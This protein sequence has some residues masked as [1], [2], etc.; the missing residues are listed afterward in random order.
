MCALI[1]KILFFN[2]YI[3]FLSILISQF[4]ILSPAYSQ[5][6]INIT[7]A[8]VIS[9]KIFEFDIF[10]KSTGND[11]ILSS[12]QCALSCDNVFIN[13]GHLSFSYISSSSDLNNYPNYSIG[14]Q[15]ESGIQKLCFASTVGYDTIRN[16]YKKIGKFRVVNSNQFIY[17]KLSIN[18]IFDQNIRTLITD[19]NFVDITH[20]DN[21]VNLQDKISILNIPFFTFNEDDSL[22]INLK[23][24]NTY[25]QNNSNNLLNYTF[26]SG[27][28]VNA[29]LS[30]STIKLTAASNWNGTDSITLK[31][32]NGISEAVK[33]IIVKVLPVNDPPVI[34]KAGNQ[35]TTVNVPKNMTIQFTD[36]DI[37]DTHT[38]SII[39]DN[40]N[41]TVANLSGNISGST[42]NLIPKT[43]WSGT[44]NIK[45]TV[46]DNGI[47]NL[48]GSDTYCLTIT[49]TNTTLT[50]SRIPDIYLYEDQSTTFNKSFFY[51]Y[52]I[53][54]EKPDSLL[55]F[56]FDSGQNVRARWKNSTLTLTPNPNWNGSDSIKITVS[57]GTYEVTKGIKVIVD[58][59]ND[60]PVLTRVG[61]QK[62]LK[63]QSKKMIVTYSDPDS[64]ETHTISIVSDNP[65]VNIEDLNG[66]TSGSIY[67]L[68]P[69]KDWY[70]TANITVKVTDDN[71]DSLFDSETYLLT[72]EKGNL[73]PII[74]EIP[75]IIFNEDDSIKINRKY[76][77]TFIKDDNP[78]STLIYDFESGNFVYADW[79][80]SFLT[81][82]SGKNWNGLDSITLSVNDG[83]N[84]V[85]TRIGVSVS[86]VDDPPV[87]IKVGNQEVQ[88][89]NI[90]NM[91]VSFT[92]ADTSDTHTI[93]I[94]SDNPNVTVANLSGNTSG[95]KY[96]LAPKNNWYGSANITVTVK[97]NGIDSLSDSET[98]IL[99]VLNKIT[100]LTLSQIPDIKLNED[101]SLKLKLS[102]FKACVNNG[103]NPDSVLIF[104]FEPGKFVKTNFTD[105]LLTL[106]TA[107]N[108]NGIDSI[109]IKV[110]DGKSEVIANILVFVIPINDPPSF[111]FKD[112]LQMKS[113]M[114][115]VINLWSI[116]FDVETS[117][118]YLTYGFSFNNNDFTANYD[119]SN[120]DL[121]VLANSIQPGLYKLYLTVKDNVNATGYDTV[122]ININ[123]STTSVENGTTIKDYF[124]YQNFPNPYNP[125]TTI[126]YSIPSLCN[127]KLVVYNSIGQE[128]MLIVDEVQN[129]GEYTKKFNAAGLASGNYF[130][131]FF[132]K[133]LT[134]GHE[135]RD[136]KKMI[137]IK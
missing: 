134:D 64:S 93:S 33:S 22:K 46:T 128:I 120:G 11:F 47:G 8:K 27:K 60:P 127:V 24:F 28:Y 87:L 102:Y 123:N 29:I 42:Y 116:S 26:V 101:D 82:K 130:Y 2:K 58:P 104:N 4:F 119:R 19:N 49:N 84:E 40:S 122:F 36:A 61:N 79:N 13:Q 112:T 66:D 10:I 16:S 92:D 3:L 5:Y 126:K 45:I 88:K 91:T 39:S 75:N 74:S 132:A 118:Q 41:V 99:Q 51:P 113:D 107:P 125:S 31:V 81:L 7:N 96:S 32:S 18:W 80:N 115:L 14:M 117:Q 23:Y 78:D 97:D 76:F 108:K 72:V 86:S 103:G 50:I 109:K 95:S 73:P 38:I 114:S 52:I 83:I 63:N 89:N 37:S 121:T 34:K 111:F 69:S 124:L 12:Y 133:S 135:F 35:S 21:F 105:S 30:D 90:K 131:V 1:K 71:P 25:I 70:G 94:V 55:T 53:D 77:E 110:S 62:T 106:T 15:T 98:Y 6:Q 65:N 44:A 56:S 137:V 48:T 54:K 9:D 67:K 68:V 136:V 57:D 59:V 129:E 100:P 17:S 20:P 85:K 43:N